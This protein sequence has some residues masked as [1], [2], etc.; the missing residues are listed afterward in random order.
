MSPGWQ[1]SVS[2]SWWRVRIHPRHGL[3]AVGGGRL[4]RGE[5][6][7]ERRNEISKRASVF[8]LHVLVVV[9]LGGGLVELIRGHDAQPWA[10]LCAVGGV[11]YV[12][13]IVVFS[14]RG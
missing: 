14:R 2:C 1:R 4:L 3:P 13:G 10:L 9:L 6:T 12:V 8:T 11:S 5:T 7:D